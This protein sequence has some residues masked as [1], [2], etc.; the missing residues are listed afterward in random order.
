[1]GGGSTEQGKC[2]L[3]SSYGTSW[4]EETGGLVPLVQGVLVTL[5]TE[6]PE[7]DV[8]LFC[9][10]TNRRL[11]APIPAHVH[12]FELPVEHYF[13]LLD[14][15]AAALCLDVL[16]CSYPFDEELMFPLARRVVLIPDLQH[17]FYP[18]F[19]SSEVLQKRRC[20]FAKVLS[21]AGAIATLSEHSRGTLR[22]H[23]D[24]RC[25]DIFLL[26]PALR[27]EWPP[28][29]EE[30]LTAVEQALLPKGAFFV[31]PANLWAHKNH[32]R[33][34]QAFAEFV[35]R[36]RRPFELLLTGH[37]QGWQELARDFPG[38]PVRHLGFV[39]DRFLLE[40]LAQAR[41]LV[42]FSLFEGFG[43]PLLEA[44]HA[45]TPVACSN[46]TSLPE[47][48][49]DAVLTCDPQDVA[50]MSNLM[51]RLDADEELRHCLSARGKKRLG[52]YNWSTSTA[53]LVGACNR[54]VS[55]SPAPMPDPLTSISRLLHRINE[56]EADRA[57][58]LEVIQ[59]LDAGLRAAEAE[60]NA[61][62]HRIN[63][64]EADRAARLEV[65][66]RLDAGL[67]AAEAERTAQLHRINEIE[68]DRAARLEV[69]QRLD[70]RLCTSE[71][72]RTAQ[73]EQLDRMN[74][75]P[76]RRLLRWVKRCVLADH[77]S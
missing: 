39:R 71:A 64:I 46:T 8:V 44:F 28:S 72:E 47:V 74:A 31:Y 19:F 60:R 21:E 1:M 33:L 38:L 61:Q 36:T 32:R 68:A 16:F 45:G 77:P 15:C 26:A 29:A 34:L 20:G 67:R 73:R 55:R 24:T 75:K 27:Q 69:I 12:V 22:D 66:Q 59:R 2:V 76:M 13:A 51:E 63:E 11:F 18:E 57:A 62:L 5:F 70:A 7:H 50:A 35:S 10:P 48:G 25:E 53:E 58:R 54:V 17:E 42:F 56:I 52:S 49:G 9:T 4:K 43:I 30:A 65:I 3:V 41:A 23:A 40:L 14:V 37:P 6:W